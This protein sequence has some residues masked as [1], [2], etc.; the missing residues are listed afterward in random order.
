MEI[1]E[2]YTP[3][4]LLCFNRPSQTQ[5]VFDMIRQVK[6]QKLY[7]SVDAPRDSR[8]DDIVNCRKVKEI[9]TNVDWDCET[10]YLFHEKNIGC[11]R[12][13]YLAW[14]WIFEKEESMIFIEDDGLATESAFFFIQDMLDKYRDDDR[15]AYV[16]AVNHNLHFG[17]KT[18]F[19]SRYP[20]STYFMGTWRRT[21]MLYEYDLETFNDVR[22]TKKYKNS[23]W[24]CIERLILNQKFYTYVE[25]IRKGVRHN[26]YDV[27]M[28]YL[29]YKYNKYNIYPNINMVS[30][31]GTECGANSFNRS[32]S[33]YV[34]EYGN[35]ERFNIE[36][37]SYH[38]PTN[39][40][41]DTNFEKK[42][43][44]KRMLQNKCWFVVY[45]KA[46]ILNHFGNIY[47][48]YIKPLRWDR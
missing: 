25:S 22:N 13:G 4:L 2:L 38:N 12:A 29:C 30:N 18:Y 23:F 24:G 43:F 36:T 41:V 32:D 26:T 33:S 7:V 31:I 1:K 5:Q 45:A 15:I 28:L 46:F 21:H 10:H 37:I 27:Q 14:N 17:D 42:H 39:I 9:V 44:K 11:S 34:R 47:S 48:K 35:R 8:E 3:V 19:F 6:P 40:V 20:D 16:G